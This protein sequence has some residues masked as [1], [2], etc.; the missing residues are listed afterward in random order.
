ML[1]LENPFF[2]SD[3]FKVVSGFFDETLLVNVIVSEL[4][5]HFVTYFS[6]HHL[7]HNIEASLMNGWENG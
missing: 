5:G 4:C 6:C 1:L 2:L 3:S 7:D